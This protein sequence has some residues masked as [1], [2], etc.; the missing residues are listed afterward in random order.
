MAN[1]EWTDNAEFP[2]QPA[3]A[4]GV[5]DA[6]WIMGLKTDGT[7]IRYTNNITY[8]AYMKS[9]ISLQNVYDVSALAGTSAL[10]KLN[11][12][13]ALEI[14][15]ASS[16]KV[17]TLSENSASF[18]KIVD[19]LS[20]AQTFLPY[21]SITSNVNVSPTI[22]G[23]LNANDSAANYTITMQLGD[24]NVIGSSFEMIM[25]SGGTFTLSAAPGVTLNGVDGSSL[26]LSLQYSRLKVTK[27]GVN[28][29]AA[30]EYSGGGG[31]DAQGLQAN[32][33]VGRAFDY[34]STEPVDITI[35]DNSTPLWNVRNTMNGVDQNQLSVTNFYGKNQLGTDYLY[36]EDLISYRLN[37]TAPANIDSCKRTFKLLENAVLTD[38]MTL[39]SGFRNITLHKDVQILGNPTL[40]KTTS[41]IPDFRFFSNF[42]ASGTQTTL[43][44]S[45]RSKASNGDLKTIDAMR[46]R[47]VDFLSGQFTQ[48]V[49]FEAYTNNTVV[50][51]LQYD[52]LT[53]ATQIRNSTT[54][55]LDQI[56]TTSDIP[57]ATA[58]SGEVYFKGNTTTETV[59]T[60]PGVPVQIAGTFTA[61]NLNNFTANVNGTL[62]YTGVE[63]QDFLVLMSVSQTLDAATGNVA[64]LVAINGTPV[65]KSDN[66][67]F[68]G[69][70]SPALQGSVPIALV[71][72]SNGDT[73]APFVKNNT[74]TQNVT[75]YDVSMIVH[76]IAASGGAGD[77]ATS[78][79]PNI[80]VSDEFDTA[81]TSISS[82]FYQ[83]IGDIVFVNLSMTTIPTATNF[84]IDLAVPFTGNFVSGL[85]LNAT[86]T[87]ILTAGNSIVNPGCRTIGTSIAATQGSGTTPG[88]GNYV[89]GVWTNVVYQF[90]AGGSQTIP[91][92]SMNIGDTIV[93]DIVGLTNSTTSG[94][95]ITLRVLW[96]GNDLATSPTFNQTTTGLRNCWLRFKVTMTSATTFT[97][98][99]SGYRERGNHDLVPFQMYITPANQTFN[100]AINND[101]VVE[102][103]C[104]YEVGNIF[105]FIAADLNIYKYVAAT[106][107]YGDTKHLNSNA[108]PGTTE[109]SHTFSTSIE[110]L[111]KTHRETLAFSYEIQ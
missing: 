1:V 19:A 94:G 73:I 14:E 85:D 60:T 26:V 45:S 6:D 8:V 105:E 101:I 102:C 80:T 95:S 74:G 87:S 51:W 27:I 36:H 2:I 76:T 90:D 78:G 88:I 108:L 99:V 24:T 23:K 100:P 77:S 70:T 98:A 28:A 22:I 68:D 39:D 110:N 41:A 92:N 82:Q 46:I 25:N 65:S 57:A 54:G 40:E 29:L 61:G 18:G 50:N 84:Q 4:V 5:S 79:I 69:P 37:L 62:T 15:N 13:E 91:A 63:T 9:K 35:P 83:R 11:G 66:T 17:L 34:I 72:L 67:V 38:Y 47:T 71:T 43:L 31:G 107:V 104:D 58:A 97:A 106:P 55:L 81:S 52:G 109:T 103:K 30:V 111:G 10:L 59:I 56:A 3:G 20:G 7:N 48:D 33:L 49:N 21:N 32:Y 93:L 53:D 96:G 16:E 42:N 75:P 86:G 44:T 89:N 12:T 64:G